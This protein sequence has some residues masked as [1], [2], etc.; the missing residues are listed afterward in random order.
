MR[1]KSN[2]EL[3]FI[4]ARSGITTAPLCNGRWAF[5][6]TTVAVCALARVFEAWRKAAG[7]LIERSEASRVEVMMSRV[8]SI[9]V[10]VIP[11]LVLLASL[12]CFTESFSCA[13][14]GAPSYAAPAHGHNNQSPVPGESSLDQAVQRW[15]RRLNIQPGSE[16]FSPPVALALWQPA[17][18][19]LAVR[20]TEL[21]PAN[22][23]LAQ[24]W[25]FH[26]RAAAEPRAPSSVS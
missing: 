14:C 9:L 25:Q 21:S 20:W 23:A 18:P 22:L 19:E 12:D 17:A 13:G 10:S 26:W 3:R 15:S 6:R 2:R 8:K 1:I 16:G 11:A 5:L 7:A 24:T 4:S